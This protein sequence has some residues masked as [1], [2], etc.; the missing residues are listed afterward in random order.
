MN[1]KTILITGGT[2]SLGKALIKRLKSIL[3]TNFKIIV[4]SRDEGKQALEFGHDPTITRVI[5]DIR[6]FDKLNVTLQRHK[7]DYIIHTAA[8][9]RIDDMEFYP[10]ECVKTNINGSENVARAALENNIKKCILVSTDKACQPVNVYGS[11]KFIAERIFTNYDYHSTD[12]IFASVRYGNVIASRGS[13]VPLF[14]EWIKNKQTIR[15]TSEE[16]TRFLFTLDD[17]VGAVLGALENAKGGEVFVPQINSYTLP[18][19]IKALEKITNETANTTII[20]LR[21]GEK[22][23]EDMLAETELPFTYQVPN[24]NLLQIRPQITNKTYQN[25]DKYKG[26]HFNSGLWVKEDINELVGLI[27]RGLKC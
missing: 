9:K 14:M 26:P 13:F 4:Y 2:G 1:S 24:I 3:N 19:C 23:H 18:T 12:T 6:D 17:A 5:G 27:N 22:L 7:V 25:W 15:V 20:G 16:M 21:P 11:S 8:L 10:D